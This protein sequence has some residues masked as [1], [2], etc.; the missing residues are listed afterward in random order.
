MVRYNKKFFQHLTTFFHVYLIRGL[1]KYARNWNL[2]VAF[3]AT[4]K[5]GQPIQPIWQQFLPCLG[6]PSKSYLENSISSIFLESSRHEKCCQILQTLFWV[7]QYLKTQS[8]KGYTKTFLCAVKMWFEPFHISIWNSS[9]S[10]HNLATYQWTILP[11]N[12]WGEI[13]GD[14]NNFG[15]KN[16]KS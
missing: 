12:S 14:F 7:F 8:V 3:W 6:L 15:L 10:T 4:C 1:Q 5:K 13:K 2:R 16:E 9:N 11:C